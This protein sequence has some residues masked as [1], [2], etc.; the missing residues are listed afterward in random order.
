MLNASTPALRSQ[1]LIGL[2]IFGFALWAA[3]RLG[4]VVVSGDN[5]TLIFTAVGTA[6]C[7]A[8]F[9]ILRDWRFG[10]FFFL[11]WLMFEDLIRKYMGNNIALFFGK[12][13]LVGLVYLALYSAI[14]EKKEKAFRPP[15]ALFLSL[16]FWLGVLQVF[17]Q[18][19]PS[20]WYG[21]LGLKVYFYYIPLMFVGYAFVR[22]DEDLRKFLNWNLILAVLIAGVGITQS[23]IGNGFLNPAVLAPELQDLGD[24]SKSTPLSNQVFNIPPS[25]FVSAGRY[26]E[27]L[28]VVMVLALGTSGY[29]LLS[30]KKGRT[31]AYVVTGMLG[32]AALLSG[33]RGCFVWV[34]ASAAVLSVA[35]LW[36]APWR[37]RQGHRM[38]KAIRWS[39]GL[40]VL[41][42]ALFV[43]IFPDQVGSRVAYYTE[44]LLPG[45][46][47]YE[48]SNRAW[49]YP[50]E[51]FMM[52]FGEPHWAVGNGI[53][54]ASLGMQYVAKLT[55]KPQPNIWVEEGYGDLLIEMGVM[56]PFLWLLWTGALL[57]YSW[58][59]VRQLRETRYFPLAVAIFWYAFL[60]L[61]PLTYISLSTYQNYTC[62]AYFWLLIGVLFRLPELQLSSAAL[63]AVA[64]QPERRFKRGGLHF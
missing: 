50:V 51:N 34:F 61:Y 17:N 60:L 1:A 32:A 46:S 20:I 31:L 63:P 45:S 44:T 57:W 14:R 7:A 55:G 24:L 41:T 37:Q 39:A 15:F 56:A 25:V 27:Y 6:A 64:P 3:W 16:F 62:N 26:T 29:L 47:A 40:V 8:G 35:F 18:N 2:V 11:G 42:L 38:V 30:S 9:A 53:G 58:K 21:L 22:S 33:N 48:A 43:T 13:I 28:V 23:I 59:V 4:G 49:D 52:V 54:T 5:D 12:D 19:S 36:G 10:T